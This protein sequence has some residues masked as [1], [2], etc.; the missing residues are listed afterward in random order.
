MESKS[1]ALVGLTAYQ[2]I[3]QLLTGPDAQERT[4]VPPLRL[5]LTVLATLG[6][7]GQ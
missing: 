6:V 5:L 2:N 3:Y 7:G 1:W 4:V